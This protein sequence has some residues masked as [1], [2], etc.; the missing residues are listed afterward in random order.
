[1]WRVSV[2]D[3]LLFTAIIALVLGWVIDRYRL[4]SAMEDQNIYLRWKTKVLE[5]VLREDGYKIEIE[6][7]GISVGRAG[8]I[9]AFRGAPPR[10]LEK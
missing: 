5:S 4:S 2:R 8:S 9:R 10:P 1:M 6:E 3:I 7:R